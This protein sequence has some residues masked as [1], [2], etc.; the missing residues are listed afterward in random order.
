MADLTFTATAALQMEEQ[1]SL[2]LDA[3]MQ[4]LSHDS[5]RSHGRQRA[6]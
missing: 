5:Q 6:I 1:G 3:P 4:D 2:N